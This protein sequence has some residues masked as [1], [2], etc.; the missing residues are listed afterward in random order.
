MLLTKKR[1]VISCKIQSDFS[2]VKMQKQNIVLPPLPL[3]TNVLLRINKIWVRTLLDFT[4][5]LTELLRLLK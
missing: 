4:F 1:H 5:A 3:P 2:S